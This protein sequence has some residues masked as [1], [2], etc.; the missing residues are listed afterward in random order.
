[1]NREAHLQID[2]IKS[3]KYT[4]IFG[5]LCIFLT[6]IFYGLGNALLPL[7]LSA[8]FAYLLFPVFS[9]LEKYKITRKFT[10]IF[11][12]L[13]FFILFFVFV[14]IVIPMLLQE[15]QAFLILIPDYVKSFFSYIQKIS[16]KYN[17]PLYWDAS[18]IVS[19]IKNYVQNLSLQTIG[20]ITGLL[21]NTVSTILGILIFF[22]NLFMFPLFFYY[23]ATDYKSLMDFFDGLISPKYKEDVYYYLKNFN[24]I[25]SAYVRGQLIVVA[26]EML[27]YSTG[28]TI[29]GLPFGTVVGIGI[30]ALTIIPY[31]GPFIG[32]ST[33]TIIILATNPSL[34]MFFKVL[35]LFGFVISLEN[36]VF[37]PQIVGD[38]V[39]L[40]PL[41]TI[42]ALV[43]FGNYFGLVGIIFAIPVAGMIRF[44][45]GELIYK[46]H[47]NYK[48]KYC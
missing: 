14:L 23:L 33:C 19:H 12:I 1:M 22:M 37:M 34:F 39:G 10:V 29:L 5:G 17:V 24:K 28:L 20:V 2:I 47:E 16:E 7:L 6:V 9:L 13:F 21:Q 45:L 32:F 15:L 42:I 8:M 18:Q 30:G 27:L 44:V 35:C 36:F 46:L 48:E 43:I 41:L 11:I 25:V 40:D 38:K 26:L 31:A 4:G 3:L